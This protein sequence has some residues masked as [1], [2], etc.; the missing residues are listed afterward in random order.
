MPKKQK[1]QGRFP[2]APRPTS[3][4]IVDGCRVRFTAGNGE[5]YHVDLVQMYQ[6]NVRSGNRRAV[7][8]KDGR[9]FFDDAL[10][11]RGASEKRDHAPKWT[12]Y[13]GELQVL[14]E[15]A[16]NERQFRPASQSSFGESLLIESRSELKLRCPL[17]HPLGLASR[18]KHSCDLCE[19]QGT[20]YRCLHGCDYD[21]CKQCSEQMQK[22]Q[23]GSAEH[24]LAVA[25]QELGVLEPSDV[26]VAC[27]ALLAPGVQPS[28]A[29]P[30]L[31]ALVNH[32]GLQ[33]TAQDARRAALHIGSAAVLQ[34]VLC[35]EP[36]VQV[37]GLDIFD[38]RYPGLV[39]DDGRK[40]CVKILSAR[41]ARLGTLAPPGKLLRK[42][43]AD[44]LEAWVSRYFESA[45]RAGIDLP[46]VVQQ[47]V[48]D[49][50]GCDSAKSI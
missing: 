32:Q 4:T 36:Q 38:R 44:T 7:M 9:W 19:A 14:L 20:V 8:R 10:L 35:S 46:D 45:T 27:D 25:H 12:R 48:L 42:V 47:H 31:R 41:G 39:L 6:R 23:H 26:R 21:I 1:P 50:I 29:L 16:F 5:T 28:V 17:D 49:F 30:A 22:E 11:H 13:S 40:E 2:T 24:F 34:L 43:E 37:A 15:A 33:F 18:W 3:T